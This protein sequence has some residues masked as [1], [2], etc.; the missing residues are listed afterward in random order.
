M[1][2]NSPINIQCRQSDPNSN[3]IKDV[4]HLQMIQ[5]YQSE[6][7]REPDK[8]LIREHFFTI[9]MSDWNDQSLALFL[10]NPFTDSTL[11]A[12]YFGFV[13]YTCRAGTGDSPSS[14]HLSISGLQPL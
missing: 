10:T 12:V 11:P 7:D 5:R 4:Q 13:V 8:I 3:N 6:S 14:S 1:S 2:S 9:Q